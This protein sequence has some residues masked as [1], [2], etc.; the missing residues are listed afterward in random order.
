MYGPPSGGA[1]QS[2]ALTGAPEAA[3]AG[4][5]LVAAAAEEAAARGAPPQPAISTNS[6]PTIPPARMTP[7]PVA[8]EP[9]PDIDRLL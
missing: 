1:G 7:L 6:N 5:A 4:A 3:P 9:N 8:G 2:P